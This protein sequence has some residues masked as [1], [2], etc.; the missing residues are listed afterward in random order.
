ME[1]SDLKI[2]SLGVDGTILKPGS[3]L[4]GRVIEYGKMVEKYTVI[5]PGR[6]QQKI[7]L[8][9]KVDVYGVGGSNKMVKLWRLYQ[10]AKAVLRKSDYNVITVQDQYYLALI[11]WLIA[12]KFK[13]GLES[14]VHGFEKFVGLRRLIANWVIP[15]AQA[16]RTVSQRLRRQLINEFGVEEK[17]IT[18]VPI[19]VRNTNETNRNEFNELDSDRFIFLT[20]GRLVRVKNVGMQIRAMAEVVKKYKNVELWIVGAGAEERNL[21]FEIG[22]LGLS[23]HVKMLGWQDNLSKFYSQADAFLLTSNYEGWGLVVI[24]AAYWRLPVIMTDVGCA[25]EVVK[26]GKSGIVIPVGDEEKLVMAM[27]KL[28]ESQDLREKLGQGAR[29]A[30]SSLPDKEETLKLYLESWNKAFPSPPSPSPTPNVAGEGS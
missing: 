14:Q 17:R 6:E 23:E 16:I 2:L 12:R 25:R 11:G 18:V 30:A 3:K 5:A 1:N 28:I 22:N 19:F 26:D 10:R 21:K 4:A 9:P 13:I 8:S 20:V 24:E 7:E 29:A 27:H 15:R